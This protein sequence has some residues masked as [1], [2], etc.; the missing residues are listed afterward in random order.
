MQSAR[1]DLVSCTSVSKWPFGPS[2]F[3]SEVNTAK[4][5]A[6]RA[7]SLG[8]RTKSLV[9]GRTVGLFLVIG[10]EAIVVVFGCILAWEAAACAYVEWAWVQVAAA[11][12]GWVA[13][14]GS[15]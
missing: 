1:P 7:S 2:S 13:E 6:A 5:P 4:E 10:L 8:L 11:D 3:R 14:I 12:R 9:S 15:G